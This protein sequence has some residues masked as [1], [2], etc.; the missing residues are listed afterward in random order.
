MHSAPRSTNHLLQS[1]PAAEFE[2]L[3]PHLEFV[4]L[5][6]ETVLVEAGARLTHV[7]LPQ[8]AI[9]SMTV[10]LSE[11]QAVEVAL[12][13]RDSV[14][15]VAAALDGG[16][17]LTD[18][19]VLLSGTASILDA[20]VLRAAAERSP[21]LRALLARHEQCLVAQAQ[22]A[23]ACNASHS[24]EARL[25]RWLL[26]AR[27]LTESE[28]LPLT[29]ECLA[30]M[31]GVQRNAVSIVANALQKASIISYS[32]GQIE[33][34]NVAALRETACEC[35]EAVKA[36]RDRLLKPSAGRRSMAVVDRVPISICTKAR[37]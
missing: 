10:R 13:G 14:F 25:S 34:T 1:L 8:S 16:I 26:C 15:G 21:A 7:Y 20:A 2:A 36:R 19:V 37:I 3:R 18:A 32:R 17:A 9:I 5:D 12:V 33:I 31:I 6:R 35:Y 23:A 27:E 28:S 30:Q 11:G 4:E 24:V 22:Q 29:Q